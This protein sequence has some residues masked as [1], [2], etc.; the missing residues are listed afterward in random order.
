MHPPSSSSCAYLMKSFFSTL[1]RIVARKPVSSSTVTHELT[2]LNQ[3]ICRARAA[4]TGKSG[5]RWICWAQS[6]AA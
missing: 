6:S 3:W 2:M 4:Q 5:L 1:M